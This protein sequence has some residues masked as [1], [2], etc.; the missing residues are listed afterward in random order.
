MENTGYLKEREEAKIIDSRRIDR[1]DVI[2]DIVAA[3]IE[4][5]HTRSE[6]AT[7]NEQ[8][9]KFADTIDNL[10]CRFGALMNDITET[11]R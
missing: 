7:D 10:A 4:R 6:T 1:L 9:I 2:L 3:Q 5:L 8:A 11:Q